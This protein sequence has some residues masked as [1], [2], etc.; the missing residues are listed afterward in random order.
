MG[1]D[2][3]IIPYQESRDIMDLS[4]RELQQLD[5]NAKLIIQGRTT[6]IQ[7]NTEM[8]NIRA[9]ITRFPMGDDREFS[10]TPPHTRDTQH[11][12][13]QTVLER[14]KAGQ[15]QQEV[16]YATGISQSRVSQIKRKHLK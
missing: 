8:G 13:E 10:F 3:S 4:L 2:K 12:F 6:E 1:S 11:D 9:K 14:L 5:P 16:A 15:T 7:A